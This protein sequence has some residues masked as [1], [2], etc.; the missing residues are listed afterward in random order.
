MQ[1]C[2]C[3]VGA[4]EAAPA[5]ADRRHAEVTA[6]LLNEQIGGGLRHAEERVQRLV[7]RHRRGNA[8]VVLVLLGQLEA[9]LVLDERQ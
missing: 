1:P 6:V 9:R 2:A 4:G 8:V 3:M 5:K 7:D